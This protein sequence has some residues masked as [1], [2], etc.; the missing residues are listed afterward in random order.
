[1]Q[2]FLISVLI[3][4]SSLFS[5]ELPKNLNL[6]DVYSEYNYIYYSNGIGIKFYTLLKYQYN[7][8][9]N[10]FGFRDILLFSLK[11][12]AQEAKKLGYKNFHLYYLE[13]HSKPNVT[14]DEYLNTFDPNKVNYI[15]PYNVGK[16][17]SGGLGSVLAL[18]ANIA[19]ATVAIKS[20]SSGNNI[21]NS[22]NVLSQSVNGIMTDKS[23]QNIFKD[24]GNTIDNKVEVDNFNKEIFYNTIEQEVFLI[25]DVNYDFKDSRIIKFDVQEIEQYFENNPFRIK[26]LFS[27]EKHLITR[28]LKK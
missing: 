23:G 7:K 27:T 6:L 12:V 4:C 18:G 3:I 17:E 8:E 14:I 25:D 13:N 22:S 26:E 5:N 16:N 1:M 2:K 24:I 11:E 20:G 10:Q 9:K 21:S 15:Y 19:L 28:G